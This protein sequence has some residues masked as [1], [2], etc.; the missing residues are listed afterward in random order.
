M[1]TL[2]DLICDGFLYLHVQEENNAV[3]GFDRKNIACAVCRA[4]KSVLFHGKLNS[5]KPNFTHNLD[6]FLQAKFPSKYQ[7]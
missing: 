3:K 5:S 1:V 4:G 7:F 6:V 2:R